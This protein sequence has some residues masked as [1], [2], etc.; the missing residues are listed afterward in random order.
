MSVKK[1]RQEGTLDTTVKSVI[2]VDTEDSSYNE[3]RRIRAFA[4]YLD[5]VLQETP[6][7]ATRLT[8]ET[9]T[10]RYSQ[11]HLVGKVTVKRDLSNASQSVAM[12]R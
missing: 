7:H 8:V 10:D 6:G 2:T 5:D 12:P 4:Q 3:D 1:H 9:L 11:V